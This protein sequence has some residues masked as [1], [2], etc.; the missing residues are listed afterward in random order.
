MST[1]DF[2][3]LFRSTVGFDRLFDLLDN[4]VRY[5]PAD[6]FPPYDIARTGEDS[7]RISLAVAGFGPDDLTVSVQPNRL[8]VSGRPQDAGD[9]VQHL[10]RGLAVRAFER[11]FDLADYVQ[12]TR[13]HLDNGLLTIE[14]VR[15]LPEAMKPRTIEIG[16]APT[17]KAIGSKTAA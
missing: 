2:A 15:E 16:S 4:A 12:V 1:I 6:G 17:L 8:V 9:G 3:P 13:A 11:R 7:Y 10:H 14:L 5:V